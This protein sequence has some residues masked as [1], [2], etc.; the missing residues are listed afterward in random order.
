MAARA[1][2]ERSLTRLQSDPHGAT[3]E[4]L[5]VA[6]RVIPVLDRLG[7]DRGLA[8]AWKLLASWHW[9]ACN[10]EASAKACEH[11]LH[12]AQRAGDRG[13]VVEALGASAFAA[14][15]GYAPLP[16]ASA[17]CDALEELADGAPS[18]M[19]SLLGARANISAM[20][21]D[22]VG[23]REYAAKAKQLF[24]EL[25]MLLAGHAF[26]MTQGRIELMEGRPEEAERIVGAAAE[27]LEALGERSYLSTVLTVLAEAVYDQGRYAE[28]E[29]LGARACELGAEDDLAAQAPGRAVM[30]KAAAR[31]GRFE[32]AQKLA[33]EAVAL[34]AS[35]DILTFRGDMEAA[36]A[37]VLALCGETEAADAARRT[38]IETYEL[39]ENVAGASSLRERLERIAA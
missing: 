5:D 1:E 25:G 9:F 18:A 27:A 11:V 38:A 26:A 33:R 31:S 30:A 29:T 6:E 24:D 36:L 8:K 32:E 2:V 37:E 12:H 10:S 7:D 39:K 19:T 15:V 3:D 20:A 16:E 23:A 21:G 14:A 22:F 4:A 13:E 28:A 35:T 34:S 17:R